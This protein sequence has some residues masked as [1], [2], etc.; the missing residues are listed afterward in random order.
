[1]TM[2]TKT[3]PASIGKYRIIK[4]EELTVEQLATLRAVGR[5]RVEARLRALVG[6]GRVAASR[7]VA[8]YGDLMNEVEHDQLVGNLEE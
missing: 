7:V 5:E 6:E 2:K 3:L 8:R 1:M 4:Q